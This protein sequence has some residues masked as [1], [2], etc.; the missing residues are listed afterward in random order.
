MLRRKLPLEL[1]LEI[2]YGTQISPSCKTV[3]HLVREEG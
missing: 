1:V 3:H 2:V